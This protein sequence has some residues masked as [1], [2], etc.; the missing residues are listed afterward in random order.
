VLSNAAEQK[1]AR[2]SPF[3]PQ[4]IMLP[5]NLRVPLQS[6]PRNSKTAARTKNFAMKLATNNL[7][8]NRGGVIIGKSVGGASQRNSLR[9]M[10]VTFFQSSPGF[11]KKTNNG[12]D[13]VVLVGS[14]VL[15]SK[16]DDLNKE[17]KTYGQLF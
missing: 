15:D 14:K 5:K 4:G 2:S 3:N 8:Y 7:S 11:M 17:L 16:L 9:R 10:V 13:F 6:F 12:R 1:D